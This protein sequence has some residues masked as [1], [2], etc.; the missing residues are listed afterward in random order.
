MSTSK[1]EGQLHC[2]V[3]P[4]L[5]ATFQGRAN[6][7]GVSLRRFVEEY[8]LPISGPERVS[9]VLKGRFSPALVRFACERA[10][11]YCAELSDRY[12]KLAKK[13]AQAA[14]REL[15]QQMQDAK[16]WERRCF[17]ELVRELESQPPAEGKPVVSQYVKT[18]AEEV[19]RTLPAAILELMRQDLAM[20]QDRV[21]KSSGKV[22]SKDGG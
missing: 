13:D 21:G 8:V 1:R 6:E 9:Q 20:L 2:R 14:E 10:L 11:E 16:N 19:V 15:G 5:K 12:A 22:S 4:E 3:T 17:D 7:K 18:L